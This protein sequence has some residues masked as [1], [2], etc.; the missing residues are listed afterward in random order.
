MRRGHTEDTDK[1]PTVFYTYYIYLIRSIPI[2]KQLLIFTLVCGAC[3]AQSALPEPET[4]IKEAPTTSTTV[5]PKKATGDHSGEVYFDGA[6]LSGTH[7]GEN[8]SRVVAEDSFLHNSQFNNA[9]L[10]F[11]WLYKAEGNFTQ[12]RGADLGGATLAFGDFR[13]SFFDHAK[14]NNADMRYADLSYAHFS[15]AKLNGAKL[16][17]ANLKGAD[18]QGADLSYANLKDATGFEVSASAIFHFTIMPDGSERTD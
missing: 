6:D 10:S 13:T 1:R 7:N 16:E 5:V 12:F 15:F 14:L 18:F 3:S 2:H 8:W 11:A 17:G 9:D 4:T